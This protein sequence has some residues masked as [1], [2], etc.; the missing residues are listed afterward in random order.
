MKN[1]TGNVKKSAFLITFFLLFAAS[2][3]HASGIASLQEKIYQYVDNNK[4]L[5][6]LIDN[7]LW[8][9]NTD[10]KAED[11]AKKVISAK[12]NPV[13]DIAILV[14]GD[15]NNGPYEV[16]I[17]NKDTG[18]NK[19]VNLVSTEYEY[20]FT[21]MVFIQQKYEEALVDLYFMK[22]TYPERQILEEAIDGTLWIA[23]QNGVKLSKEQILA[24]FTKELD[25]RAAVI[26]KELNVQ[27]GEH[28]PITTKYSPKIAQ[29]TKE[30]YLNPN[31]ETYNKLKNS[32][33][34][35][36]NAIKKEPAAYMNGYKINN[37]ISISMLATVVE[38]S[39]LY[40]P[41]FSDLEK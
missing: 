7:P 14:Y 38:E 15:L 41:S 25:K 12:G 27:V 19:A 9:T 18:E 40:I 31:N 13:G 5:K 21:D 34:A 23:E 6:P 22:V 10:K 33:L 20:Y 29:A 26:E 36:L 11:Y 16:D 4:E 17:L 28:F 3:A 8:V 39:G 24:S 2:A 37:L 32:F 1:R 30:Y 35:L